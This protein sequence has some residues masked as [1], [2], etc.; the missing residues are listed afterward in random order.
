MF[1]STALDTVISMQV[2][3]GSRLLKY[4]REAQYRGGSPDWR[5]ELPDLQDMTLQ[6]EYTDRGSQRYESDVS[7]LLTACRMIHFDYLSQRS[8]FVLSCK[9]TP[10][11]TSIY[12]ARNFRHYLPHDLLYS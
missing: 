1:R 12:C 4:E 8:L 10:T 11:C 6:A 5:L 9:Q 7:C 2:V 3:V